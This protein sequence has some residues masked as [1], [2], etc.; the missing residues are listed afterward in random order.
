MPGHLWRY[1]EFLSDLRYPLTGAFRNLGILISMTAIV[2]VLHLVAA[3]Y[4]PA[5]RSKGDILRFRKEQVR[6]KSATDA[7]GAEPTF[8]AQD[9]DRVEDQDGKAGSKPAAE[10][11]V[12]AIQQQSTVFHFKNLSYD[13]KTPD[14]KKRILHK[15]DGWV[16]PGTLT[17]LMVCNANCSNSL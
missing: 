15:V 5:Q 17:A 6:T 1:V 7:E 16:K 3:E 9:L 2:C 12:H 13:V 10:T 14:G 8:F 11:I 4:I